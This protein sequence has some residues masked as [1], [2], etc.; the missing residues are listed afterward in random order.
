[1]R[2]PYAFLLADRDFYAP[3]EKV[4]DP[5]RALRPTNV[6]SGW[7]STPSGIWTVWRHPDATVVDQGWKVH[8]SARPDRRDEV[9]DKAAAV[10]FEQRIPFKHLS[11]EL[12]HQWM[13]GKFAPRSQ[14]GKFIAAYPPDVPAARALMERLSAELADEDGPYILSDRRFGDS[15]TVHYR[16]GAFRRR[17]RVLVDGTPMPLVRDGH[18]ELVED[19][20]GP[21]FRLPAGITDPFAGAAPS[22]A[23]S[24]SRELAFHGFVFESPIR[25]SNSGGTYRGR[26]AATGRPVFIKEARPH[27][28][29]GGGL[30]AIERLRGEWETLKALQALDPG[31]APEPIAYFREWEHEF[32]V[33]EFIEGRNLHAWMVTRNPIIQSDPTAED[34]ERYHQDCETLISRIESALDRLHSHGYVFVDVSPGNVLVTPDEAVRLIDFEAAA[35]ADGDFVPLTTPGYGPPQSLVGDDPY[36]YDTYALSALALLLLFPMPLTV[37][38]RSRAL[39]HLRHDLERVAPVPPALWKR[40]TRHHPEEADSPPPTGRPDDDVLRARLAEMRDRTADA[41]VAMADP[42]DPDRVFPTVPEGYT[43]NALCVAYGTA[44]VLHALRHAGRAAPDGVLDRFR[45]EAVEARDTL[46]PGLHVGLAGVA[47]VLADHGFLTEAADLLDTAERHPLARQYVTLGGGGAGV[48]L[49]RLALYR[50]TG[51][52][53]HVR[54]AEEWAAA[55]PDDAAMTD[56]VGADDAVGLLHGRTGVAH[57]LQQLA[58]VTGDRTP[59]GRGLRLMH[60]EMDRATALDAGLNFPVSRVDQRAMP[61]IHTGTAGFAHAAGRYLRD[62][63]D[64]RLRAAVPTLLKRLNTRFTVMPGLYQGLS[65]LGLVLTEHARMYDDA[66][67]RRAAWNVACGLFKFALPHPTGVRFQGDQLLRLSA[68]LWSGSAGVLLFLTQL[69]QPRPD[70]FFTVDGAAAALTP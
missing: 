12:F 22:S 33:A 57:V 27:I 34:F 18:G 26:E 9:L 47:W 23:S 49:T 62:T 21:S 54:R 61:Y 51:D 64:E 3:L 14:G 25:F 56:R 58:T 30:T 17:E 45:R 2:D 8:V 31:L 60:A 38:R 1:M 65:G 19:R 44:G 35:R 10:L 63:G 4:A 7:T 6:P 15:R 55:L 24:S 67:A 36:L 40:V 39:T 5:G 32:L 13:H 53:R 41:L 50:H 42:D 59:L 70:P 68:D 66:D 28:G 46:G 20:R 16:Y 48:A 52:E 43:A 29:L 37:Q 11:A 69:L